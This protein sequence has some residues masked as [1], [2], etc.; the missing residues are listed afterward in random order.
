M[1]LIYLIIFICSFLLA[2]FLTPFF[3][4][5]ALRLNILDNPATNAL[6]TQDKPVPY[7]GGLAIYF[8]FIIVIIGVI[9][10]SRL[11]FS[12]DIVSIIIGGTVICLLGFIDDI[13]KLRPLIKFVF[14][15][16]A[17]LILIYFDLRLKIF[18]LPKAVNILLTI[19]WIVGITNAFNLIDIMDGLSGGVAFIAGMTFLFVGLPTNQIF[20]ILFSCALTGSVIGFLPY[21]LKPASIYM[22]D[23]GSQF[24]GFVLSAI[25]IGES[26]TAVNNAALLSPILILGIPVYDTILVSILRI[27][28]KKSPF[29]GSPDHFALRLEAL[30]IDRQFVVIIIYLL[31]I[32]LGQASYI[33]TQVNLYGAVFTYALICL[34]AVVFG[35]KLGKIKMAREKT[36]E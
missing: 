27:K 29:L 19:L 28:Q 20:I 24:L 36:G 14:Q 6:K 34:M 32:I 8:S 15:F 2:L 23:A 11:E 33:A 9:M 3:R 12:P 5:L 10:F 17:A 4:N 13:Y 25:A 22:G 1:S 35:W 30:G 7:L 31:T 26:Y 16:V 18:F 21:N